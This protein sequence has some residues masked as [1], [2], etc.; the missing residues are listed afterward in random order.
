MLGR[1]RPPLV[2][3]GLFATLVKE[4]GDGV[5]ST[6]AELRE[7]AFHD[8][9]V[10]FAHKEFGSICSGPW[11]GARLRLPGNLRDY[12]KS[13]LT[14]GRNGGPTSGWRPSRRWGVP[15]PPP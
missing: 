2:L 3:V 6:S 7:S 4:R 15:P 10:L 11:P 9:F 8:R 1:V 14:G 5:G 13:G 12:M